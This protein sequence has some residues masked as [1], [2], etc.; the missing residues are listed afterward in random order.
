MEETKSSTATEFF[1]IWMCCM[2][3]K[4]EWVSPGGTSER[5]L[6]QGCAAS[7]KKCCKEISV[8]R[9]FRDMLRKKKVTAEP[10]ARVTVLLKDM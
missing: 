3:M 7:L 6:I 1:Y 8:I 10:V 5:V 9:F 2:V 4:T